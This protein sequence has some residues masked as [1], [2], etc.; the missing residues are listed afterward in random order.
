MNIKPVIFD[1]FKC[2][3]EKCTD[4]CCA[5]W[6]VD[7]D[8]DS[9]NKYC[10]VGGDFG[11]R[12]KNGIVTIDGQECFRLDENERCCFLERN[13]LCAVY[14]HLGEEFLCEICREHPRFYD[15]YDSVTEMGLGLCCERV[16]EML[17]ECKDLNLIEY[18][19]LFD[20]CSD[21]I[22]VLLGIREA[23][24]DIIRNDN[25]SF[26]NRVKVLLDYAN[27]AQCECF[28]D[29][30]GEFRF[31]GMHDAV[32]FVLD[33][34]SKTEPINEKWS[35]CIDYL[36]CFAKHMKCNPE[37]IPDCL[38]YEK[39]LIYII[40]RH[41]MKCRFDGRLAAVV[42]FA[43]CAVIFFYACECYVAETKGIVT[44]NDRINIVKLWSQQIEYSEENTD[45][46]LT[47]VE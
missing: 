35:R 39:L 30:A 11:E 3:A 43:V 42:R 29:N 46:C 12:L 14:S 25:I 45:Y 40:Y 16:C 33:M 19:F 26:K 6:E 28:G 24:F 10:S 47:I 31:N 36:C 21:D 15:E 34:Y 37:Y 41:F 2:K 13:G 38:L 9:L 32:A 17:F 5:G 20:E 18:D 22:S 27:K 7:I 44:D 8:S 1:K 23:C 4:T